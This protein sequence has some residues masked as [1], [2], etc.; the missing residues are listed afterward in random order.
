MF[1][2]IKSKSIF[3]TSILTMSF[4][5]LSFAMNGAE[6]V[7]WKESTYGVDYE[8]AATSLLDALEKQDYQ[9]ALG[10]ITDE[11]ANKPTSNFVYPIHLAI[12][13]FTLNKSQV[14]EE[15][16]NTDLLQKLQLHGANLNQQDDLRRTPLCLS[17]ST[18]V[19]GSPNEEAFDFLVKELSV[20]EINTQSKSD[21]VA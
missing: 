11:S 5:T 6:K 15:G 1:H 18:A 9:L 3:L 19:I 4:A 14:F 13:K 17:I 8:I 21:C 12:N 16:I 7:I 10:L 2:N 20:E